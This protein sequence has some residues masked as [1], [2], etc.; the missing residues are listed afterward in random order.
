V[1]HYGRS[2]DEWAA[3]EEAG[4]NFLVTQARLRQPTTYTEMN[5]ALAKL[6]DVRRFDFTV[7]SER[8]AM[9][10]LLG[11]LSERSIAEAGVMISSLVHYLSGNDA[12][13]GF[14]HLAQD[15]GLLPASASPEQKL[16]FW[17]GQ[18]NASYK[19]DWRAA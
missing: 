11:R 9:G 3:L 4:W 2:D 10:D 5:E 15:K 18:M 1:S 6:A 14:Y 16:N 19:H 13:A 17:I 8:A 12:G 7:D